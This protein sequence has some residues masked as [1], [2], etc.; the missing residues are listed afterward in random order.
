MLRAANAPRICKALNDLGMRVSALDPGKAS[1]GALEAHVIRLFPEIPLYKCC[2]RPYFHIT[3]TR[4]PARFGSAVSASPASSSREC[5]PCEALGMLTSESH[6]RIIGAV[7]ANDLEQSDW[8]E[9]CDLFWEIFTTPA[10]S[11][12]PGDLPSGS[13]PDRGADH[14][15]YVLRT[16]TE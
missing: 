9:L 6:G 2:D 7:T 4:H 5:S 16:E 13:N 1:P 11:E 8:W 14:S 12:E 15:M 3:C 10:E